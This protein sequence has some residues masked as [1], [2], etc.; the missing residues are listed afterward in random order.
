M[1]L[2]MLWLVRDCWDEHFLF[3]NLLQNIYSLKDILQ[4]LW[5]LLGPLFKGPTPSAW[6]QM[7]E[8]LKLN[9]L[10]SILFNKIFTCDVLCIKKFPKNVHF[11]NVD[12][13]PQPSLVKS[14]IIHQKKRKPMWYSC[15]Y[16]VSSINFN[17]IWF[18]SF[19]SFEAFLRKPK[20]EKISSKCNNSWLDVNI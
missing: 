4:I 1:T 14:K 8:W 5:T 11:S 16:N 9:K 18:S 2:I 20:S 6:Y 13:R 19:S 12:F 7:K 10:W 3:Y 17:L 15:N